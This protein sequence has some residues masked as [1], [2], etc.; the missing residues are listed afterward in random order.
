VRKVVAALRSEGLSSREIS[1]LFRDALA[2]VGG[3]G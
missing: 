1:T 2:A 3:K